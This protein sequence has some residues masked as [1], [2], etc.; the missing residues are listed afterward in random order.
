MRARTV[1]TQFCA[2]SSS[3]VDV[4][5]ARGRVPKKLAG[6]SVVASWVTRSVS[7]VADRLSPHGVCL[8]ALGVFSLGG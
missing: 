6:Q 1:A 7:L 5:L 4:V 8:E 3:A 2:A